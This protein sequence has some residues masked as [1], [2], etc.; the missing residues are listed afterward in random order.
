MNS[1]FKDQF[2]GEGKILWKVL[3]GLSGNTGQKK[4]ALTLGAPRE[5]TGEVLAQ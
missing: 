4:V 1:G 5:V 2:W 3:K